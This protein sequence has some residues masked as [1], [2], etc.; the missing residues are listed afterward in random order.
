MAILGKLYN[1]FRQVIVKPEENGE[2]SSGYWPFKIRKQTVEMCKER[3]GELLEMGCGEGLFLE[4]IAKL[5]PQLDILG[6]D[7][8]NEILNK[9][10]RRIEGANLSNVKV[11]LGEAQNLPLDN[12]SFDTVVCLNM[13]YNLPSKEEVL[14]TIKEMARVCKPEGRIIFDIRNKLNP[15]TFLRFKLVK[16]YD[17]QCPWPL[18]AYRVKEI[19]DALKKIGLEVTRKAPI[20]FPLSF[21][22]PVVLIEARKRL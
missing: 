2:P 5:A 12:D 20:G 9:A 15:E 7:S 4:R 10:R 14:E 16:Y 21:I 17:P 1:R 19:S 11:R 3:K 6:I 13:L 22:A 18:K 8:S